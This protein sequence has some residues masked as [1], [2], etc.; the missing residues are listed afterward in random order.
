[1]D[2]ETVLLELIVALLRVERQAG[3]NQVLG[4][5]CWDTKTGILILEQQQHQLIS[6]Q[7]TWIWYLTDAECRKRR[8]TK[9]H[10]DHEK[11]LVQEA[12]IWN[13]NECEW[14]TLLCQKLRHTICVNWLTDFENISL[15]K[16]KTQCCRR[17]CTDNNKGWG[18]YLTQKMGNRDGGKFQ[19]AEE[20]S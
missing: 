13:V 20:S 2:A 3:I 12:E 8:E 18:W 14:E 11:N 19:G 16:R 10:S 4:T 9:R 15:T 6:L 1:M 17:T 7:N 5:F